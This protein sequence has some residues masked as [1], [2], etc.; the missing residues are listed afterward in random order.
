MISRHSRPAQPAPRQAGDLLPAASASRPVPAS[1][2]GQSG[3]GAGLSVSYLFTEK[4]KKPYSPVSDNE[5]DLWEPR[6][7]IR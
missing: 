6:R 2:E 1:D 3:R 4:G 5:R 7:S